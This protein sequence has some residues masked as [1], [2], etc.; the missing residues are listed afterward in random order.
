LERTAGFTPRKTSKS[1]RRPIPI[2]TTGTGS[3]PKEIS[4]FFSRTGFALPGRDSAAYDEALDYQ[5]VQLKIIQQEGYDAHDFNLFDDRAAL[6]WRKPYV[7]GA[8]RELTSGE[9]RSP[10]E[11][12]RTVE[13]LM[14]AANNR[15]PDVRALVHAGRTD[16]TNVHVTAD[17]D[18]T[19]ALV[20]SIRRDPDQYRDS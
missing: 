10:E 2:S 17:V 4:D 11:L 18:Q 8:V 13:Q 15:N 3:V 7:D 5:D 12:R 9:D 14:L 1:T 20:S 16:R 6:L 19:E